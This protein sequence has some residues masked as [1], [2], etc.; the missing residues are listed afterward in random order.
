V[1][2]SEQ[3][4][5]IL[6]VWNKEGLADFARVLVEAGFS[7]L[8]SSG[9]RR[10]LAEA[11]LP[12]RE[13][14]D[15][16]GYPSILGGRVKTLH[17]AVFGGILARD[18]TEDEADRERYGIPR[19]DLVVC[20]LYPF[21]ETLKGGADLPE[22]IEK[23]DIG[24]VSLLRAAAKNQER[25]TVICDP[26][27]YGR[28]AEELRSGGVSSETRRDLALKAF[29]RTAAYDSAISSGLAA[30][31]G[32]DPFGEPIRRISLDRALPLRYGEN[33]HQRG[34]LFLPSGCE[35]AFRLLSGKEMSYNN[36]LDLD[37]AWRGISLFGTG[38][39]AC[40]VVKH[41][42]PCGVAV[43]ADPSEA[44]ERAFASDPVS[45]FGG[46]AAWNAPLDIRAAETLADR[47]LEVLAAPSV[48]TEALEFLRSRK[49]NLRILTVAPT[50]TAPTGRLLSTAFGVLV[51]EDLPAPAPDPVS[52]RW[53]G[54]PRPDLAADLLLAWK[55]AAASKS[56]A[57]A[58]AR[59]GR[60]VGIGG[61]FTN[62]VDAVRYALDQAGDRARGAVLASDA[63][64]PFPDSLEA[65]AEAGI[66]AVVQPGGSMRDSEVEAA[67]E[68]LGISMLVSGGR[69]FRH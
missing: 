63:F 65:A 25:V 69:T 18:K 26:S 51:Q 54:I 45:A 46:I 43:G 44:F 14:G 58:L 9:T 66:T 59:E 23:I 12:A 16:T 3:R 21:E 39:V 50:T 19:I 57:I 40:V 24:G 22:L 28:V 34:A 42:T 30:A 7:L 64:F 6:S 1:N 8:A 62:R 38:E 5:A 29:S 4:Y 37:A 55:S 11:G 13:T 2:S 17:P 10:T 27:D 36:F 60:T 47:F 61:G 68:R 33:P 67:A 48:E 32:R 52:G 15:L 53:V 41:G 31:M 35:P 56:N 20:T 49:K